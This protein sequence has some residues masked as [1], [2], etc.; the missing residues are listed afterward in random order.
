MLKVI[1]KYQA[2]WKPEKLSDPTAPV[3][4]SSTGHASLHGEKD[5]TGTASA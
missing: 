5:V 4:H 1:I 2:L 3:R